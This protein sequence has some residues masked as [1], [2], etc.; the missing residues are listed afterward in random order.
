MNTLRKRHFLKFLGL[1]SAAMMGLAGCQRQSAPLGQA[2]GQSG[3]A[4]QV[5]TAG[6][7]EV[8]TIPV[9][10]D[11]SPNPQPG[12]IAEATARIEPAVVTIDTEYRPVRRFGDMYGMM[13]ESRSVPLGS[14]SGVIINSDGYIVTNNHVIKGASRIVVTLQDKRQLEG[15]VIGA[16][17]PSDLAVVKVDQKNLPAA[18]LADSDKVKV[19]EWVIAVGNPLGVGTTVTAGIISAVREFPDGSPYKSVLQTDAAINRGNSGGALADIK[20][21]LIGIN[22]FILSPTGG[23]IGLGFAIP[24]NTMQ[25]VITELISRGR[26]ARPYFGVMLADINDTARDRLDIPAGINGAL[27]GNV[28][29]GSPAASAGLQRFDIIRKVNGKSLQRAEEFSDMMKNMKIGDK[30]VLSVWREGREGTTTARV[31]E[32]PNLPEM[33]Q[34]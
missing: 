5:E 12:P 28:L 24:S 33:E 22:S 9:A 3:N 11:S 1:T 8:Q 4:T 27:V 25:K 17:A 13:D 19:G 18:T 2:R 30:L 7:R 6:Q 26:I 23:S 21:R 16:D 29:E 34:P 10:L 14:G 31:Q 20:G 32:R 15:R